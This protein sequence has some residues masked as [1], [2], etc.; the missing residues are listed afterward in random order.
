MNKIITATL[1]AAACFAAATSASAAGIDRLTGPA[2]AIILK[3]VVVPAGSDIFYLSGQLADPIDPAKKEGVE[4]YGDTATQTLSCLKK[5]KALLAE[6]GY[7]L[8]DV[9]K[10]TMFVAAD[11]K[12]GKADFMGMNTA[13][14]T[15]F[16]TAETPTTVARS[17][18]Q[19]AN[20]V[21][22]NFLIEIE[23]TAAKAK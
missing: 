16:G 18:I 2:P 11:P 22:P 4:A 14:K 5:I 15:V 12:T 6:R 23:A 9:I 7:T 1:A 20:L 17:T 8:G 21:N 3:G 10:L 13:F 19:V